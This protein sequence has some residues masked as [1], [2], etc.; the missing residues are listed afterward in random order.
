MSVRISRPQ[1]A[2]T[3]NYLQSVL[4]DTHYATTLDNF[5]PS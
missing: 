2:T 5:L 4:M 3:T 1:K